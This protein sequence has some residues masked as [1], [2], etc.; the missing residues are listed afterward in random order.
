MM[1]RWQRAREWL[2]ALPLLLV[3]GA[4]YWLNQQVQP[5]AD[6]GNGHARHDAD[7]RVSNFSVT[8]F[9]KLGQPRS[10]MAAHAML[11]YPDDDSTHLEQLVLTSLA[12]NHPAWQ[13]TA[14]HGEIS[15]GG[16]EVS[17][18]DAVEIVRV[19]SPE[20]AELRIRTSDLQVWP[21]RDFASTKR[22]VTLT[23]AHNKIQAVGMELDNPT[24]S[25]KLLAQ[26][27]SEH[28]TV[29]K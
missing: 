14:Q 1:T 17:L 19:A 5:L 2:P 15:T 18:H 23:D 25:I 6:K 11:H 13:V 4:A 10:I 21:A 20:Q 26:V 29:K 16:D 7:Y 27:K 9:S 28:E 3:L 24:R 12:P 8:T 22:V